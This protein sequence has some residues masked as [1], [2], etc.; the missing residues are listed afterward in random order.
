MIASPKRGR[1]ESTTAQTAATAQ[2]VVD[3]LERHFDQGFRNTL[4]AGIGEQDIESAERFDRGRH[5]LLDTRLVGGIGPDGVG[6]RVWGSPRFQRL[7]A[8][9]A[10]RRLIGW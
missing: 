3:F 4:G 1:C 2:D 6:L 8:G 9:Y 5:R 10:R 7:D